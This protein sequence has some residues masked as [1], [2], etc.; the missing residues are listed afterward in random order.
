MI[1]MAKI[2]FICSGNVARSQMAEE[3]YNHLTN[4]KDASSA[5]TNPKTPKDYPEIPHEIVMLMREE[6]IDLRDHKVKLVDELMIRNCKR[7]YVMREK[8]EYPDEI[9]DSGK[10]VVWDVKDPH[11]RTLDEMREIRDTIKAQVLLIVER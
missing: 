3:Y 7:I 5:G 8:E 6:D 9:L 4:S 2:L 11:K 10:T 1:S